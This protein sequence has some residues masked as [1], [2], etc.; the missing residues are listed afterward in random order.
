M[1]ILDKVSATFGWSGLNS[2]IRRE[3]KAEAF[4]HPP[5]SGLRDSPLSLV[6]A[7]SL[8]CLSFPSWGVLADVLETKKR[9][10]GNIKRKDFIC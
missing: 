8:P 5:N 10:A 6:S 1:G 9:A 2:D 7:G 3:K 4:L